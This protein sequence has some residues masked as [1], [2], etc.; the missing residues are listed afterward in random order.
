MCDPI[1][2]GGPGWADLLSTSHHFVQVNRLVWKCSVW[3]ELLYRIRAGDMMAHCGMHVLWG[4]VSG[5]RMLHGWA[6]RPWKFIVTSG[7]RWIVEMKCECSSF[8]WPVINSSLERAGVTLS[9]TIFE[10]GLIFMLANSSHTLVRAVKLLH[11]FWQGTWQRQRLDFLL[12]MDISDRKGCTYARVIFTSQKI[13]D[14][15][16][17]IVINCFE[18]LYFKLML[19]LMDS[20]VNEIK[21]ILNRY[22]SPLVC[23]IFIRFPF[24]KLAQ[25]LVIVI[26]TDVVLTKWTESGV[27]WAKPTTN[28]PFSKSS[29][30]EGTTHSCTLSRANKLATSIRKQNKAERKWADEQ[31]QKITLLSSRLILSGRNCSRKLLNCRASMATISVHLLCHS[32]LKESKQKRTRYN[33]RRL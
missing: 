10:R 31:R 29:T 25:D 13:C 3:T 15:N 7:M 28:T 18:E 22:D 19:G 9:W 1:K 4:I 32:S 26:L 5:S 14:I 30:A 17:I 8:H 20:G 16:I 21:L 33:K 12:Q 2:V 24:R 23:I 27:F 11:A 6:E